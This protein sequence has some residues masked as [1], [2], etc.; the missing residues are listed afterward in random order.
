MSPDNERGEVRSTQ[1]LD[2]LFCT[3]TPIIGHDMPDFRDD[4]KNSRLSARL[5]DPPDLPRLVTPGER[6]GSVV[7]NTLFL[8]RRWR[9]VAQTGVPH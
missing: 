7:E 9:V 6:P 4:K 1:I 5:S 2:D 8:E 3:L